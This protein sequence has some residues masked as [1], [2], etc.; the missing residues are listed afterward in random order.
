MRI[1]RNHAIPARAEKKKKGVVLQPLL[2]SKKNLENNKTQ[3]EKS[4]RVQ[5]AL[6]TVGRQR[7]NRL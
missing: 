7:P 4:A 5:A 2:V 3:A 1:D 6:F